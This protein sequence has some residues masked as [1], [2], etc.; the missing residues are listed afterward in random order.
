M[1]DYCLEPQKY[2]SQVQGLVAMLDESHTARVKELWG[3]LEVGCGLKAIYATPYPH[4]SFH[5]AERYVLEDMDAALT[6]L[7]KTIPPFT[8]R[9][10]G[11]S[12][13]TGPSPVVFVPLVVSQELI[14]VHQLL[15]EQTTRTAE[16]LS[17]L[18]SPG[19]WVPHITL[20]NKDVHTENIECVIGQLS[21]ESFDW[22]IEIRR[23]G[24]VCHEE[25]GADLHSM[26]TLGA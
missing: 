25:G 20:A 13:F 10:T 24:L 19:R 18:Y 26:Y 21:E 6:K 22:E 8:V 23:L 17:A 7:V 4:F 16:R 2:D 14:S 1:F 3:M 15:W 5:I 11:L 12:F 9:T